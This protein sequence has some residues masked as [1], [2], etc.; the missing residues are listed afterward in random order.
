MLCSQSVLVKCKAQTQDFPSKLGLSECTTQYQTLF[1][2]QI[3]VTHDDFDLKPLFGKKGHF[4]LHYRCYISGFLLSLLLSVSDQSNFSRDVG[5]DAFDLMHKRH[6]GS[7]C[8]CD[9][10]LQHLRTWHLT[11]KIG[12]IETLCA[13]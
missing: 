5:A 11:K 3:E 4:S 8:V 1:S 6:C 13:P 7:S 9:V 12:I 10:L 2:K